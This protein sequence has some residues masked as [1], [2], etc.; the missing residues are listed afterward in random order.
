MDQCLNIILGL[1]AHGPFNLLLDADHFFPVLIVIHFIE[2]GEWGEECAVCTHLINVSGKDIKDI[3]HNNRIISMRCR[4]FGHS[5]VSDGGLH[6]LQI[7]FFA[8]DIV[9]IR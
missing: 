8:L 1:A 7:P 5:Q 4:V 2:I 6:I 3:I 9:P